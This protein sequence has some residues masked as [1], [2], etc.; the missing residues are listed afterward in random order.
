M[1]NTGNIYNETVTVFIPLLEGDQ[2]FLSTCTDTSSGILGLLASFL[3]K[4]RGI[5]LAL[6]YERRLAVP[7]AFFSSFFTVSE[8]AAEL[9]PGPHHR[10]FHVPSQC[11]EMSGKLYIVQMQFVNG[12]MQQHAMGATQHNAVQ[13]ACV[14]L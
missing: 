1:Y 5:H 6:F 2:I 10:C 14:I 13:G 11:F 4:D 12:L 8:R 7:T 9:S 3:V